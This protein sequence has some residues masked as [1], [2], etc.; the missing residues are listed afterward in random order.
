MTLAETAKVLAV[1][2]RF[3][4]YQELS[5]REVADF[6][7]ALGDL[8]YDEAMTAAAAHIRSSKFFPKPAELRAGK[9]PRMDPRDYQGDAYLDVPWMRS[10]LPASDYLPLAER[11]RGSTR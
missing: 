2:K 8:A 4:D 3:Y 1:L 9:M 5:E 10:S 11:A 7:F 6:H